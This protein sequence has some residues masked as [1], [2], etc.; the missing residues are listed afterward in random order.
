MIHKL[1]HFITLQVLLSFVFFKSYS[2]SCDLIIQKT[3]PAILHRGEIFSYKIKILNN[4]PNLV[5]NATFNDNLPSGLTNIN[6]VSC[7]AYG[8]AVC[9]SVGQYTISNTLFNGTIPT[10]GVNDSVVFVVSGN[11]PISNVTSFSNTA[12]VSTPV[13]VT[14]IDPSTNSSTWN[15]V[16]LQNKIDMSVTSAQSNNIIDCSALPDTIHYDVYWVNHG[17]N[18]ADGARLSSTISRVVTTTGSGSGQFAYQIIN[19]LW[20]SSVGSIAPTSF[21]NTMSGNFNV[22]SSNGTFPITTFT[23]LVVPTW[24]MNDTIFLSYDLVLGTPIYPTN[25]GTSGTINMTIQ[26]NSSVN[27]NI[28]SPTLGAIADTVSTNNLSLLNKSFTSNCSFTNPSCPKIDF[29]VYN[30]QSNNSFGC[31]SLPDT[32]HYDIY[33]VNNGPIEANG[34]GITNQ[35]NK[36]INT[37]GSSGFQFS[38]QILNPT[39]YASN[40][41]IAPSTSFSALSGNFYANI[42]GTSSISS[43]T[44]N[45]V[46]AW[47]VGDTIKLSYD[48]LIEA[49]SIYT[50]TCGTSGT[51]NFSI[52][53]NAS[54]V[55]AFTSPIYGYTIDSV[56]ANNIST[57]TKVLSPNCSFVNPSCPAIDLVVIN[58]QSNN[59]IGCNTIA[60]TIHQEIIWI[61]NGPIVANGARLSNQLSRNMI[62]P[63]GS[64]SFPWQIINANWYASQG[65]TAPNSFFTNMSG[66]ITTFPSGNSMFASFTDKIVTTWETG[67]TIKLAYDFLIFPPTLFTCATT[68]NFSLQNTAGVNTNFTSPIFGYTVDTIISNNSSSTTKSISTYSAYDLSVSKFVN[69]AILLSGDTLTMQIQFQ[70]ATNVVVPIAIWRDTLPTNF[71]FINSTFQCSVVNGGGNCGNFTYDSIT[72]VL[73]YTEL[74]MPANS[75]RDFIYRG[76]V[77]SFLSSTT[78]TR[79]RA[80]T[81]CLDCI[82]A[83]NFTETN[84]QII[85]SATLS[86]CLGNYVFSDLNQD[87]IQNNGEIGVAGITTSLYNAT[88]NSI[89]ATVKTDAYGYYQFCG[90]T[91]GDYKVGFSLPTNYVFTS[92]NTGS[93]DAID[94][95]PNNI[96]GLTAIYTLVSGDSNMTVDAGIFQPI[97]VTATVGDRVWFDGNSNGIQD[98]TEYGVSGIAVSLFSCSN[99]TTPIATTV[100]DAGGNY[101]FE[102][103]APG[104]YSVGF[105]LPVGM[106][107]TTSTG[108]V[109][110]TNNSDA[111]AT[112][113]KTACF[114]V[115]GGDHIIY[116]DAGIK[117]QANTTASLGDKVWNDANHDGIQDATETGVA[118][119]TVTL[120]DATGTT[121]ISTTTTDGLGNY[122]FNGIAPGCYVVGFGLPSGYTFSAQ[123]AGTDTTKN[124]D[125]NA[126]T[127]MTNQICIAAAQNNPTIDAG[128]YNNANTNSIGDKVW[129]DENHDGLQDVTE[130]GYPGVVVTL[131]DCTTNTI[132]ATT[133]TN[134]NGNYLFDGLANGNYYVGFGF[135][136]GF[137][138]TGANSDVAG[139]AGANNSDANPSNGLTNCVTLSGNTHITTVDAGIYPGSNRNATSTLGDIVWTDV[140][141]NGLQDNGETGVPNVTVTLYEANGTTVI[142]TTTTDG[143]GNYIF[144]NLDGGNYVV[145]FDPTTL[146][147]GYTFTSQSGNIDDETNSDANTTTGKTNVVALGVGED[148]MTVDAGVIAPVGTV[149][150]GDYVWIDL[151]NNGTQNAGEP[152][153]PGVTVK[154]YNNANA[155]IQV[156]T[157]DATGKYLFCGLTN[158]ST[159]SVG[160]ENLPSGFT[161]TTQTGALNVTDNS[162]AN[163]TTGRTTTVT[164]GATNDLTL[165]AGIYSATTAVVGNY[166]WYDEDAD[167][168]QDATEAPI[169]GVLVTLYDNTNTSVASAVTDANGGYLFTNVTP[170][171]YTI[172]F[173][174]YSST[175]VPTTKGTTNPT[176]ADDDSN[177]DPITGKT[178]SFNVPAGSS[179]LT[180]DAGFKANPIAGLG[181]YVWNDV[182]E[183]GL[184]EASEPAIGGVIV[185]LYEADGITEKATAITDGNGAYSFPNLTAGD[186]VVG[187]SNIPTGYTRTLVVGTQNDALNSDILSTNKTTTITLA[188]GTYNPNIDAGFYIGVPLG[189]KELKATTAIINAN[190]TNTCQVNWY[191]VDEVNTQNFTIT[192]SIDN[193]NFQAVGT[194]NANNN[195]TGRTNYT[196]QDNIE[197]VKNATT[198]YYQIVLNDIDG[199]QTKS[200]VISVRP[201][202]KNNEI[203]IYPIPFKD[204]ITINYPSTEATSVRVELTDVSGRIVRTTSKEVIQGNNTIQLNGLTNVANGT[205]FLRIVNN[206]NGDVYSQ[207]LTK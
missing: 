46:P 62:N 117:P 202:T 16:L 65:S 174:G 171:D 90:L 101:L 87:G 192:R 9:P 167:G 12:T 94:S 176:T 148:K 121:T 145:G 86:P 196:F 186:Y 85:G 183:N 56:I 177:I 103:V 169:A 4:G 36:I 115:A 120:Y 68:L 31:N 110:T 24:E 92:S 38:W 157:T 11:A 77:Q 63:A 33:W 168:I 58:S 159:Y 22:T 119:V 154:L 175:L 25:C 164:M 162:D 29:A 166:V 128:V 193:K 163:P 195:T 5:N 132:M 158:G 136:A 81:P 66:N 172:G 80:L 8:S 152:A 194:T 125:A 138:F 49:P 1:L 75:R 205:Y 135:V 206:D 17:P 47:E 15:I 200:N 74:N 73:T 108:A 28:N 126:T 197:G 204:V 55:G 45:I 165:D 107:Y 83:T 182:N 34:A 105:S 48:L 57:S 59:S 53:N 207:K 113:G 142:A 61:N 78:Y 99:P 70:N 50:T 160:F 112:S 199:K 95:D 180:L 161:F 129:Y 134:A 184:Q 19:P 185:T 14:E 7:N 191:T 149:C 170:G 79:A 151:N 39:W 127:G 179:N 3:G 26:N 64:S 201:N 106:V 140:N 37:T 71:S 93:D 111:D 72:R 114:T 21:F 52:Q 153:V 76:K 143:L 18:L 54:S 189:V 109:S 130:Y 104:S 150:L 69:P 203:S 198:I 102:N 178:E 124:S 91:P 67:D 137:Q 51:L 30:I 2:Q 187:F 96:T 133:T 35:I 156:A 42:D 188:S 131:Y 88:T 144:T 139:I 13:S 141:N 147:V 146:P 100:T 173:A 6:L 44:Q 20:T 155:V 40:G 10:L 32:V 41:S 89:L 43:F 116:V 23:D 84:Y 98:G 190:N 122:G 181:N 97:P 60:D 123:N 27:T 82:P 118:G